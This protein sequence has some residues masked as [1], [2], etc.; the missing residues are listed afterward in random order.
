MGRVLVL[1]GLVAGCGLAADWPEWRGRG[2]TGEFSETGLV[3]RFPAAGPKVRWRAAVRG[4]YSGPAVA[5]GRVFV[6]DYAGGQERALAFDEATGKP[7]WQLSWAADYRGIDYGGGPR[8]TPTV[9]GDRVY[10]LGAA[11]ELLCLRAENGAIEWRKNFRKEYG[12]DNLMWGSACAPLVDGD[13][14]IAVAGG[15]PDA[16]IVAFNKRTG[17]EIWRALSSVD[18]EPGYSQPVL[19]VIDGNRR[20]IVWHAGAVAALDPEDGRLAWEHP[21]R[22]RMNTP[23]A[24]PVVSGPFVLVAA[25]FQGARLL[26]ASNGELLWRSYS[27][28]EVKSETL[29]SALTT[30]VID[31][32]YVYGVCAYGQLR[33]LKLKTGERVWETLELTR[34]RARYATA[35]IVRNGNRYLFHTD[36]GDLVIG[37]LT[38]ERFEEISRTHLIRPTSQPGSRRELEAVNWVHPAFANGH[39]I[40]RNDEEMIRV[41]LQREP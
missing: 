15:K 4:G 13:R 16:K 27:E 1:L 20:L 2:R 10:V 18:S 39:V 31:G 5:G 24:T 6:T 14:L 26:R 17:R 28:T 22:I 25:F 12:A 30:P 38:P 9:D 23:I 8:A 36:R 7:L 37:R 21:Y 40:V 41:S 29:H 3:E 33:C 34:E 32:D 19:A 11:G 35:F